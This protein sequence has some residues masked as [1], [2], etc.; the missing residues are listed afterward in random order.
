MFDYGIDREDY[1]LTT[2]YDEELRFKESFEKK[3]SYEI[4]Y[5]SVDAPAPKMGVE[6][7]IMILD[8]LN[9]SNTASAGEVRAEIRG[10]GYRMCT[11]QQLASVLRIRQGRGSG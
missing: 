8:E 5:R 7:Y 1:D 3:I 2:R 6:D 9:L 10:N 4:E 11:P